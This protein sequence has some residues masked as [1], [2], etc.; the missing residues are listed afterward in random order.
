MSD[1]CACIVAKKDGVEIRRCLVGVGEHVIG[2]ASDCGIVVDA[3]QVSRHHARLSISDGPWAIEDLGSA[4]GTRVD[5]RRIDGCVPIALGQQVRLGSVSIEVWPVPGDEAGHDGALDAPVALKTW[6]ASM[7]GRDRYELGEHV[8]QGGMG[9]II[10]ATEAATGRIVAM[11]RMLDGADE[12]DSARFLTEAKVTALLEHPNIVPVHE[13]GVDGDGYVFYT[14]KLV[15]G[16]TLG[17][18]LARIKRGDEATIRRYP[19][20]AL[21]NIFQ[22]VCD[23]VAFAHS[24]DVLHRDLKPDNIMIGEYGEV[25]VM[26]WGL[27]KIVE[28]KLPRGREGPLLGTDPPDGPRTLPGVVMGTPQYMAPEQAEGNIHQIDQRTDI[29]A[30]GGILYHMLTLRPPVTAGADTVMIEAAAAGKI[31]PPENLVRRRALPHCPGGRIPE[32]LSA[33]AMRALSKSRGGRYPTVQSLQQEIAAYQAG[34]AT[35]A[36][37]AG[38]WRRI[39]LM[40]RRHKVAV[41]VL[42]VVLGLIAAAMARV[43][44]SERRARAS[45]QRALEALRRLT[46]AQEP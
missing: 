35:A 14:M 17:D 36:E 23:A 39:G 22:K 7:V 26:D 28:R 10:T 38:L 3:D 20:S 33:V 15:K 27:A 31:R 44:A 34:F 12:E 11:K 32:S 40:L 37:H 6:R 19:L 4:N 1:P 42:L 5:G 46:E 2:R 9:A 13:L 30:L 24:R 41:V 45:E 18:V 25:L 8:A 16:E 29:Y 21:L 43:V